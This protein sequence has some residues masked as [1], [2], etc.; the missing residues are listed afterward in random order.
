MKLKIQSEDVTREKLQEASSTKPTKPEHNKPKAEQFVLVQ[1]IA[2]IH[3]LP[4]CLKRQTNGRN[5]HKKQVY[6][7]Q[8][9]DGNLLRIIIQILCFF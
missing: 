3:M 9:M 4:I 8:K 1:R 2:Q 5:P 6:I 7:S